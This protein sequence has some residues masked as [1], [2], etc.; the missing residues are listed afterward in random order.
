MKSDIIQQLADYRGVLGWTNTIEIPLYLKEHTIPQRKPK[1][2]EINSVSSVDHKT[3]LDTTTQM[4]FF[5]APDV[6]QT[7]ISGFILTPWAGNSWSTPWGNINYAEVVSYM[8]EGIL[9]R[10]PT[11]RPKRR[12]PDYYITPYGKKYEKPIIAVWE[13]AM[14]NNPKKQTF[15]ATLYLER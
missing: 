8:L 3:G 11:G 4:L 15:S 10:T 12:D 7:S 5:G 6:L 2:T 14:T 13:P 1:P 9:N